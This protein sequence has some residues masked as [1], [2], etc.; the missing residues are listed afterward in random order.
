MKLPRFSKPIRIGLSMFLGI[1]ICLSLCA[2]G[3]LLLGRIFYIPDKLVQTAN[4]P[5]R[6][7]CASLY[8]EDEVGQYVSLQDKNGSDEQVVR[9]RDGWIDR[10]SWKDEH[11]LV[12]E[13]GGD[14]ASYPKI[15]REEVA[16]V[17]QN[18]DASKNGPA[19]KQ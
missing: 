5:L 13:Y 9:T 11:T 14:L 15:W 2:G 6:E 3:L 12:I 17:Y 10:L 7:Y 16:I 4:S 19:G 18:E 1:L 8:Y